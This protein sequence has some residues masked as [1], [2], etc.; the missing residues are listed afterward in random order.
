[1][2]LPAPTGAWAWTRGDEIVVA[3]NLGSELVEIAGI[4]GSIELSSNRARDGE[5]V[6]SLT[7][8]PFEGAIIQR[9]PRAPLL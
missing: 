7:L 3:L 6:D 8:M 1:M 5:Q 4:D 2:E 9:R